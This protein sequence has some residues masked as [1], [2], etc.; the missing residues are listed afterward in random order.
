MSLHM[1]AQLCLTL[2][3]PMDVAHQALLSM[4]FSRQEY[5]S[6]LPFSSPV[7]LPDPGIKSVSFMSPALQVGSLPLV[8]SSLG[9]A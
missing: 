5:L 4:K 8:P 7:N 2:C 6:G 9:A 3:D 1:H